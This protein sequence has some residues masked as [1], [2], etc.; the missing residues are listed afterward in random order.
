MSK[1]ERIIIHWTAGTY[2]PND[3]DRSHYHFLI[4]GAGKIENGKFKPE[5]NLNCKDGKYAEHTGGGNTGSIGIAFCGMLGFKNKD[6]V[7][8]FPLQQI[9]LEAGYKFIAELCKKYKIP[10]TPQ[11]IMTH[12]EFGLAHPKTTSSGKIDICFIP[13]NPSLHPMQIGNYIRGKV[14]W[15]KD[16]TA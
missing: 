13:Y 1:L 16:K 5:D 8:S 3:V 6:N 10:I 15:Y 14:N 12:M 9:Q 4:T 11:S 7:G 2:I